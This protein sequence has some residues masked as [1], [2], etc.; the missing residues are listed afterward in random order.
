QAKWIEPVETHS[1]AG[2]SR[3]AIIIVPNDGCMAFFWQ[4]CRFPPATP[5]LS[6]ARLTSKIPKYGWELTKPG[7]ST[8]DGDGTIRNERMTRMATVTEKPRAKSARK[9]QTKLLIDGRWQ[10][11]KSGKTFETVNPAT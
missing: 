6:H 3:R 9:F 2:R 1:E 7:K 11:S 8:G 10:D 5:C 4:S